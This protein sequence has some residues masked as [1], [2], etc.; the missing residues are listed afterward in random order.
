M[1]LRHAQ[2]ISIAYRFVAKLRLPLTIYRAIGDVTISMRSTDFLP[3]PRRIERRYPVKLS[4]RERRR[5]ED[6]KRELVLELDDGEV[7]V[8]NAAALSNKLCQM[9]DGAV[10]ADDGTVTEIH[11]RKLDALED[12]VEAASGKPMLVAYWFRHDLT[13]ITAW[14][15]ALGVP[16]GRLDDGN[17]IRRWN[18]R[19]MA[20][21]LIHPASAGR[22]CFCNR[23]SAKIPK[24]F[25]TFSKTSIYLLFNHLMV[26]R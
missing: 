5:Y 9:A 4:E 26:H 21:G 18:E 13:R 11:R 17:T 25:S 8:G 14:L 1:I 6:L 2:R 19:R 15:D 22:V 7:T 3:M 20:V 16:Y 12:L 10:Y 24:E 23:K